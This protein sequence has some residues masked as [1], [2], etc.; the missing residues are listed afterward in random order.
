VSKYFFLDVLEKLLISYLFHVKQNFMGFKIIAIDGPTGVGKS[1]IA[2]QLAGK[3]DYLYVD[4]GA[5]FRC[6]ALSW[7]A[8]GCLES[9]ESL[10]KLGDQTK[11]IF[12]NERVICDDTDVT[13]E[14]RTEQISAL[15]SKISRFPSIREVMK[16]QQ[17]ALVEEVCRSESYQGAVLEGR[18]IGTVVFPA[19]DFKF[20]VD[21][22]PETRAKRRLLQLR[23]RTVDADY[24]KI[25]A[26]LRKRDYQDQNRNIAPLKPAEESIIVDTGSLSLDDV[27]D[28]LLACVVTEKEIS[29]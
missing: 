12:E 21:A 17:R 22:S 20:Y 7:A 23:E 4:T 24:E 5:M 3:L 16:K 29:Q 6:L 11:I 13:K 9:D 8:Q 18:D 19:A 28:Y 14:I 26:D 1:T 15:A 10:A 2:R 27:L 25:L